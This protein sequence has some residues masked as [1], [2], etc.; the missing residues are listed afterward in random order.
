MQVKIAVRPAGHEAEQALREW[1][2]QVAGVENAEVIIGMT[3]DSESVD[4]FVIWPVDR[5][6]MEARIRKAKER[7][8]ELRRW[9][10]DVRSPLNAIQGYAELLLETTEGPAA[11]YAGN[12]KTASDQM[13]EILNRL[14]HPGV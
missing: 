5:A 8:D 3:A 13:K 14:S 11:R 9:N 2:W 10:H 7:R 4:D 1:G 6:E 12:I